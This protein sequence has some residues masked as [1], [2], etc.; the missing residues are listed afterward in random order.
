VRVD[1]LVHE[2]LCESR[3]IELVVSI[4]SETNNVDDHI[5]AEFLSVLSSQLASL[6]DILN[7]ICVNVDDRGVDGLA[8]IS[9]VEPR[10]GADGGGGEADLVVDDDVNAAASGVVE[11]AVHLH[12]LVDST[13][14]SEGGVS[15]KQDRAHLLPLL[16]VHVMLFSPDSAEDDGVDGFEVGRV[17]EESNCELFS[18]GILLCALSAPVVLD[19]SDGAPHAVEPL[20]PSPLKLSED[21]VLWSLHDV[22]QHVESASVGHTDDNLF[23]PEFGKC[24]QDGFQTGHESLSALSAETL[25]GLELGIAEAV[26]GVDALQTLV[27]L[28][29]LLLSELDVWKRLDLVAEPRCLTVGVYVHVLEA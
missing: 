19:V 15:V 24:V 13:L 11:E 22:S 27:D 17:G 21:F 4:S 12:A 29:L 1:L 9:A 3:L 10:P 14:S 7:G 18:V 16:V 6:D 26:E 25:A 5:V 20:W 8:K 23:C 2:R 28:Q